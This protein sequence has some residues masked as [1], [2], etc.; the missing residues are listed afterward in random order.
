[1]PPLECQAVLNIFCEKE[2]NILSSQEIV[3][4]IEAELKR[5]GISKAQ[6]YNDIGIKAGHMSNWRKGSNYPSV[7][8]MLKISEYLGLDLL[9]QTENPA[10][11]E[12]DGGKSDMDM[13][14]EEVNE[15]FDS[16]GSDDRALLLTFAR[17]L[18]ASQGNRGE[19][20]Q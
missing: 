16:F 14:K 20:N 18:K 15:L 3:K 17:R 5:K 8:M 11:G 6:F 19:G 10:T 7:K 13:M 2:G 1:M 9:A 12:G 4:I